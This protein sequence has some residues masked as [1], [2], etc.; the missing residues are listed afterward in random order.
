MWKFVN[1]VIILL[2]ILFGAIESFL[3]GEF[4][5]I[6]WDLW[7]FISAP[8]VFFIMV[9]IGNY[10]HKKLFTSVSWQT[11]SFN[12]NLLSNKNPLNAPFSLG[13]LFIALGIGVAVTDV[14]LGRAVSPV[15]IMPI[16]IGVGV[17]CAGLASVKLFSDSP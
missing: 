9:L 7:D 14:Y 3:F 12:V 6:P 13:G 8:F 5:D 1:S 17:F 16:C 4:M 15:S 10:I 2:T 11:P